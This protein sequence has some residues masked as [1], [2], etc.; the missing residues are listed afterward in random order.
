MNETSSSRNFPL[1]KRLQRLLSKIAHHHGKHRFR[2]DDFRIETLTI[3]L[4]ELDQAFDGYR[5][6]HLTDLHVG[7]WLSVERLAGVVDLVNQQKPD[8]ILMT[9]DYVSYEIMDIL[10]GMIAS[11]RTMHARDGKLAVLGNHDH[12][13]DAGLVTSALREGGFTVLLNQVYTINREGASLQIAGIDSAILRKD[14]L[15]AVLESLSP[16]GPAILLVHEP[17]FADLSAM[18]GRFD[19]QLSGHSHGGQ[20]VLPILGAMLRGPY[21]WKYPL[22]LYRVGHVRS[23]PVFDAIRNRGTC[24]NPGTSQENAPDGML[25]YT[26]RGLGTNTLRFRFNC[27]PEILL[28]T[29]KSNPLGRAGV[30][31]KH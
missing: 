13:I 28:I 17:D 16:T 3:E 7:Q 18:S 5:M 14:R 2:P 21:F 4:R 12:W 29:L 8:L 23:S 26:N 11:M 25:L 20:I 6:V 10:E 15:K 30:I 22:G 24:S 9:G 1:R 19:L 27:P 31:P